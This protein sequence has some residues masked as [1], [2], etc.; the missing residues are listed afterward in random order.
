MENNYEQLLL[1]LISQDSSFGRRPFSKSGF[2][3]DNSKHRYG[4]YA[5]GLSRFILIDRNDLWTTLTCAK[6]LSSK[7]ATAVISIDAQV[8]LLSLIN[9]E[10]LFYSLS[11]L[12]KIKISQSRTQTPVLYKLKENNMLYR[13]GIPGDF[14]SLEGIEKLLKLQNYTLF[15]QKILYGI[16]LA[17]TVFNNDD[18]EFFGKLIGRDIYDVIEPRGDSSPLPYGIENSIMKVL[19]FSDSIDAALCEIEKI[20]NIVNFTESDYRKYFYELID[21]YPSND[22]DVK[23]L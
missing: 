17:G 1:N 19:Y 20:W 8:S 18:L 11:E 16:R 7:I 12:S 4:I 21:V 6:I 15:V 3:P 13:A 22:N 2:F 10:P 9:E 5:T 14:Q 23:N